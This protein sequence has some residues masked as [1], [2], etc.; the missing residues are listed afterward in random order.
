MHT[1]G[2]AGRQ[3]SITRRH[4]T[5]LLGGALCLPVANPA[6]AREISR[7]DFSVLIGDVSVDFLARDLETGEDHVLSGSR[8]DDRHAPWSTFKIPNLLIA[9]ETGVAQGL[10]SAR[11]WDP[12]RRPA[13]PYWPNS[14][15]Q[16]QTLA[17]AFHRSA[18]WYFQDIA[19]EVGAETYRDFLTGWHYG[20]GDVSGGSDSFWLGSSLQISIAEQVSFL[21]ALVEG[22][23]GVSDRSFTAL[24]TVSAEAAF[25]DAILHGKTGSGPVDPGNFGG[26]FEGW[27]VGYLMRAPAAPVVFAL[28]CRAADHASIRT[29]RR[30]FAVTLL[31]EMG[32]LGA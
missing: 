28:Y 7:S 26:D 31:R 5:L 2:P 10:D 1:T 20:N 19:L 27:Y 21:Q 22:R 18:V 11:R 16:D 29:F 3:A 25:A 32:V 24:A 9:L 12:V 8:L 15:R 23:L 4:A 13:A 17:T 6:V 14:W 30:D